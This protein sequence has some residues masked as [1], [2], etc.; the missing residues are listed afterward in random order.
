LVQAQ[1]LITTL[2]VVTEAW[3]LVAPSAQIKLAEFA[4][5]ALSVIELGED[6]MQRIHELVVRYRDRPMDLA[7]ASLVVLAERTGTQAIATIDAAGFGA[8]RTGSGKHFRLV[9]S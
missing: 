9:F 8:F 1:R 5:K 4:A 7:D 2:P 6:A 3:H